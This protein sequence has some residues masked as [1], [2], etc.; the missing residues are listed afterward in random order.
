MY[1]PIDLLNA[2][3]FPERSKAG[4]AALDLRTSVNFS[5]APGESTGLVG[6]GFRIRDL[7]LGVA[8]FIIPRSGLGTKGLVLANQVGLI[9][10]SYRG[11]IKAKFIWDPDEE[12]TR[13][14]EAKIGDRVAQ[15]IFL[16]YLQVDTIA[17]NSS[18]ETESGRGNDGFGSSGV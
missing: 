6:L 3:C 10:P 15:M 17:T 18:F 16:P 12:V 4:D 11:E 13:N 1:V 9:D 2:E 5:L 14:F 8:A 7:P